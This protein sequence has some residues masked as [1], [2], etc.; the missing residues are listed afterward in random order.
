MSVGNTVFAVVPAGIDDPRT[1]SGGNVYDRRVLTGLTGRGWRVRELLVRGRWPHA[2][3]AARAELAAKLARIPDGAVVL[4]DGIVASA[5]PEA[6]LP[7]S[8]RLRAVVL[9][10]L[11]LTETA[12]TTS[13]LAGE[14]AVLHAAAAVVTTSSWT[15]RRVLQH[16]GLPDRRVHV[17]LP[18]VDRPELPAA[19]ELPAAGAGPGALLCVAPVAS[20][21]GQDVL[22]DA[23][24]ALCDLDWRCRC[25]GSLTREPGFVRAIRN[26]AETSGIA[27]R[28]SLDGPLTG[29]DLAGAYATSAVLVH[30]S[31]GETYG[32]VLAEAIAHGLPV[33]ATDVGG[34]REA[35]ADSSGRIA[36][37]VV[38]ADDPSMLAEAL[39]RW[40]TD[41]ELRARLMQAARER[42]ET[43]PD[44]ASTVDR[45][46]RVLT[47]VAA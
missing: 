6:L 20:H 19:A 30:P 7:H 1:P 23:L 17:A 8:V 36:G 25:V 12:A 5:A 27:D 47:G 39:R 14:R 15:R 22:V 28:L 37:L 33:I 10:H 38:A 4:V 21:K 32:M 11:P 29:A 44:W 3:P 13:V 45:V 9:I 46:A 41:P 26:R 31:R 35:V 16:Y 24:G 2:A 42:R 43:L 40:L 18:G 34:T